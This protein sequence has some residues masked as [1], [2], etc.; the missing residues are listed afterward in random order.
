MLMEAG[1]VRYHPRPLSLSLSSISLFMFVFLNARRP[2]FP[3]AFGAQ[4]AIK[5][6]RTYHFTLSVS[7]SDGSSDLT[8]KT[9][10]SS[11]RL[12]CVRRLT[13]GLG[14]TLD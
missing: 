7:S 3:E 11:G 9:F 8:T 10:G 5:I 13:T 4:K 14:P 12:L 2:S 1:H 6:C